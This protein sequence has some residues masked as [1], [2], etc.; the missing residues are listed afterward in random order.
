M[1]LQMGQHHASS[2]KSAATTPAQTSSNRRPQVQHST[3]AELGPYLLL[4]NPQAS[5]AMVQILWRFA[6]G[7]VG[8]DLGSDELCA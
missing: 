2:P 8:W 6:R 5:V 7:E 3:Q 1:Q 4:H